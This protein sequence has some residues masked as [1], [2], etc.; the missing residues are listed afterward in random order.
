MY[1]KDP[2]ASPLP[3]RQPRGNEGAV[4]SALI[5]V[6]VVA[7]LYAVEV[8]PTW[9]YNSRPPG[10]PVEL[11]EGGGLASVMI[12]F[13]L[14]LLILGGGLLATVVTLVLAIVAYVR[15]AWQPA[16]LALAILAATVVAYLSQSRP[17][18]PAT[19]AGS[20]SA[21]HEGPQSATARIQSGHLSLREP[22][23]LALRSTDTRTS[24][25]RFQD[26]SFLTPPEH[27]GRDPS[28]AT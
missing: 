24:C 27:V 25:R 14:L 22:R 6:V 18:D 9:H 2:P 20:A 21:P 19:R 10:T 4:V 16:R 26:R 1:L 12:Y 8:A 13:L 23:H 17:E 11:G 28:S 7:G 3:V 15:K 5:G